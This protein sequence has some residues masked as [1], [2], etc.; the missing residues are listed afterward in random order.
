MNRIFAGCLFA[1]LVVATRSNAGDVNKA[2]E[3]FGL[4]GEWAEVDCGQP[5]SP[6]NA[7]DFW[8]LDAGGAVTEAIDIGSGYPNHYRFDQAE[9]VGG[10]KIVFDGVFLGNGHGQHPILEKQG[11]KVRV[12]SNQDMTSG[13]ML[14]DHAVISFNGAPSSWFIKCTP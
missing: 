10:D 13:R 11:G 1:F 2:A 14:V 9:L 5:A 3:A 8:A 6:A 4:I 12:Y 7:H